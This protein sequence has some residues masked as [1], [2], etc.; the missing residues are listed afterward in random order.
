MPS[1]CAYHADLVESVRDIREKTT[2]ILGLMEA[3]A[4]SA[5]SW[6]VGLLAL[7]GQAIALVGR[8]LE[9]ATLIRLVLLVAVLSG[10]S[11]AAIGLGGG[12]LLAQVVGMA[13]SAEI[14]G[15]ATLATGAP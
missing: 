2:K 13:A 3:E 14:G 12:D 8:A 6:R 7:G 15:G 11:A 9:P 4:T 10:G 1:T 5:A